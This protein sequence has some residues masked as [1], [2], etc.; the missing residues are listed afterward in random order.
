[1]SYL[2]P[3]AI[4]AMV[5]AAL[6]LPTAADR[7][8][9]SLGLPAF[10]L[11]VA[12]VPHLPEFH[13]P[14]L[15]V[16]ISGGLL[17]LG[18]ALLLLAAWKARIRITPPGVVGAIAL[19]ASA[20]GVAAAWPT[21]DKGGAFPALLSAGAL[22]LDALLLWLVGTALGIGRAVRW[23]DAKLPT[24][25]YRHS[26]GVLALV[27]AALSFRVG[28]LIW[29]LWVLSWQPIGVGVGVLCA[30][31]AAATGRASLLLAAVALGVAFCSVDRMEAGWFLLCAAALADSTRPRVVAAVAAFG[32]Y[33]AVPTLLASEVLFTVLFV[34]AATMLLGVLSVRCVEEGQTSR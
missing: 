29:P 25:H 22:G 8:R 32:A 14:S 18:P 2:V 17:L 20:A 28:G 21:L 31:W 24:L 30:W 19:L 5:V 33:L 26:W 10:V 15:A 23:L 3:A 1:M 6:L 7:L 13:G 27:A 34:L 4:A 11:G 16:W 9:A 12:S